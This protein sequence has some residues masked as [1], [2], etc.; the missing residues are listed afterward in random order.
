MRRII[1]IKTDHGDPQEQQRVAQPD[2][3][4]REHRRRARGGRASTATTVAVSTLPIGGSTPPQRH[5]QPVGDA[6]D[7]IRHRIAKIGPHQLKQQ[8]QHE[9]ERQQPQQGIDD[10]I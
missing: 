2:A 10:D 5:D 8:P 4:E 9:R 7:R 6:H 3:A 1:S